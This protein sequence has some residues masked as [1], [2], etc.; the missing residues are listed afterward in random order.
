MRIKNRP[1]RRVAAALVL[2]LLL[3]TQALA[4]PAYLIPG[5]NTVGIKLYSE[6]LVVT[7]VED[8]AAAQRAGLR[9]GD[10]IV[11]CNGRSVR[12][13]Q[14]L[15][16][17]VQSGEAVVLQVLRGGQTAEFLVRPEQ[18]GTRWQ[19]GV[20]LRDNVSGIGTVTYYDPETNAFGALG[21]GVS[22]SADGKLLPITSGYLVPASVAAVERGVRG[23]PGALHGAFDVTQTCGL[24]TQ[25]TAHGL[26]GTANMLPQRAA[27]PVAA[28]EQV[29][30]GAATILANVDG[31][32]V[33]EY[34]IEITKIDENAKTGRDLLL[35][36][37]DARLLERTGGVVQG[38]SGSPILQDGRMVGAV[39]HVLV[40]DPEQGYGILIEHMLDA[41]ARGG[42][43]RVWSRESCM[44]GL[45]RSCSFCVYFD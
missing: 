37:N 30:T 36:M 12:A 41:A 25:N 17:L 45:V 35:R 42:M 13:A 23:T 24:V 8:G 40:G 44:T 4:R 6:G 2:T 20:Q 22:G 15:A 32:A 28:A 29:H 9:C 21:H 39:T 18:V 16:Q 34:S 1:A 43:D 7:Q 33:E 27:L 14:T 10:R 11:K 19:L 26:F 5:G 3:C 31:D 38:M